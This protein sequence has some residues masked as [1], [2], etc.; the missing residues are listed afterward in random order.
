M[1]DRELDRI[2]SRAAP[3]LPL[4]IDPL[5]LDDLAAAAHAGVAA[6]RPSAPRRRRLSIAGVLVGSAAVGAVL[7]VS[8]G[9]SGDGATPAFA[10]SVVRAAEASPR[11]LVAGD[12]WEIV[13][14]DQF[15]ADI[16][17]LEFRRSGQ[18]LQLNW[19]PTPERPI[20]GAHTGSGTTSAG[21]M[22]VAGATATVVRYN[23]SDRY[24]AAW[25]QGRWTLELDGDAASPGAFAAVLAALR[26]ADVDEW[27]GAMPE[28][29]VRPSGRPAAVDE[30]LADVPLPPGLDLQ[31]LRAG[32]GAVRDRYQLGAEVTGTVTCAWIGRWLDARA[33]GDGATARGAVA[34]MATSRDWAVLR[35]M[36]ADGDYPEVLWQLADAMRTN[37]P[38]PAG[39][40]M[41]VAETY[42]A[43]LGCPG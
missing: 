43:S 13:R 34:A 42:R 2:V 15:G 7:L 30:M 27:L 28:S 37:A 25:R 24:R 14:A 3:S 26:P 11:L 6:R 16:G 41:A 19:Y 21:R 33:A 18:T 20:E 8:A 9:R 39:R 35:A 10:A 12:G 32:T 23:D 38:V 5:P 40:K 1:T 29:A 31:A 4:G 36:D 22:S 17:E